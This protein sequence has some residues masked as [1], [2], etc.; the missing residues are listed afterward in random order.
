M[1]SFKS[2]IDEDY[3]TT[4]VKFVA[5]GIDKAQVD[6][7]IKKFKELSDKQK[8]AGDEKNIDFWAKKTFSEFTDFVDTKEKE[9]ADTAKEKANKKNPGT[10]FDITTPEQRS[11]GWNIIIPL[12]KESSCYSGSGTDW[13]VTKREHDY[14]NKYFYEANSNL[15]FCLNDKKEKWAIEIQSNGN[16]QTAIIFYDINDKQISESE[17]EKQTKLKFADIFRSYTPFIEKIEAFKQSYFDKDPKARK[18]Q[19]LKSKF[20]NATLETWHLHPNGGGWVQNTADVAD[21]AFVG[22][23]AIVSGKAYVYGKARVIDNAVVS[24]NAQISGKAVVADDARVSGNAAVSGTVVVYGNA[25]VDN[26]W[27]SDDA[28]V[29]DDARVTENAQVT[30]NAEISGNA[31]VSGY[32]RV[33]EKAMVF[34][35]SQVSGNAKVYGYAMV[36]GRSRVFENAAVFENAKV[37]ENAQVYGTARV[38]GKAMVFE[39]AAVFENAKVSENAEVSGKSR[40][41]GRSQVSGNAKVSGDEWVLGKQILENK[42]Q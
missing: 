9:V 30:E 4:A 34:G 25:L 3:K 37:S 5:S 36:F 8:L 14:F 29:G 17:F 35:S 22:P 32:A 18:L 16:R 39:N 11:A 27:V 21:T 33:S 24:G 7:Y 15:I 13:C 20:P 26:A 1:L 31:Q 38:S 40:V 28:K 41:F 6:D 12:D 19:F 23:E 42:D 10:L 2:F